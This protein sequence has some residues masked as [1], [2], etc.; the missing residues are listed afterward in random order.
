MHMQQVA[1]CHLKRSNLSFN[2]FSEEKAQGN[3][4][5]KGSKLVQGDP[6]QKLQFQMAKSQ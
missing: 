1:F 3:A 4:S 2:H 6:N 5:Y